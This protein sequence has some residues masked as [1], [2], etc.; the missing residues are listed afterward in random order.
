MS[1]EGGRKSCGLCGNASDGEIGK[2]G[3]YLVLQ[4]S[5]TDSLKRIP[6]TLCWICRTL[7][8]D[9]KKGTVLFLEAGR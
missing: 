7:T 5:L 8:L 2:D 6:G 3:Q 9:F 1:E 4:V